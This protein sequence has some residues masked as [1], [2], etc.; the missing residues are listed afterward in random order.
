MLLYFNGFNIIWRL[1][2]NFIQLVSIFYLLTFLFNDIKL[3]SLTSGSK[4]LIQTEFN[5]T[6]TLLQFNTCFIY[7]WVIIFRRLDIFKGL[8][9]IIVREIF[10]QT[11]LSSFCLSIFYRN[12]VRFQ[13]SNFLFN[14]YN[15]IIYLLKTVLFTSLID[16]FGFWP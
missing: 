8:R 9:L 13:I 4:N 6:R 10:Y 11:S 12:N 3:R 7:L 2:L 14:W 16:W 15:T 1:R 5:S